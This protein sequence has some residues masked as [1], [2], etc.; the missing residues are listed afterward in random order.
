MHLPFKIE[1]SI[2]NR[3]YNLKRSWGFIMFLIGVTLLLILF[4]VSDIYF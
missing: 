1:E 3:G 4:L 2:V